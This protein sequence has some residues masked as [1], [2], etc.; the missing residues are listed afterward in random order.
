MKHFHYQ[1]W[2]SAQRRLAQ[3]D[4]FL[5]ESRSRS[6]LRYRNQRPRN[7]RFTTSQ[8]LELIDD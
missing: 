3:F 4:A 2:S 5:K 6:S 7:S 1:N 8:F